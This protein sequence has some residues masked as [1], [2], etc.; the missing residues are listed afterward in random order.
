M[1]DF[2]WYLI[3]FTVDNDQRTEQRTRMLSL[4]GIA[5]AR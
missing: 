4:T 5:E 3:P 1:I 2:I